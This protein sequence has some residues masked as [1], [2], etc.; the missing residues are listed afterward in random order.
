MDWDETSIRILDTNAEY[1]DLEV[2]MYDDIVYMR[3]YD[4]DTETYALIVLTPEMTLALSKSFSL[5]SGAYRLATPQK[6][7][8]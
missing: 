8:K 5:P 2:I 4:N 6:D 1:G 3:Q 7:K